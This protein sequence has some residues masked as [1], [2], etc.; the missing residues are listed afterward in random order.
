MAQW[1]FGFNHSGRGSFQVKSL[2]INN[3]IIQSMGGM[4][5]LVTEILRLSLFCRGKWSFST[6]NIQHSVFLK[7][8]LVFVVLKGDAPVP[9]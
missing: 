5:V 7:S 8:A 4:L 3:Q 6:M 9:E 2:M 1:V